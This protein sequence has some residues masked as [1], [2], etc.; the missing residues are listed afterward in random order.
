MNDE[1]LHAFDATIEQG[2]Q[3]GAFVT[4]PFDMQEVFGTRGR[5][6]VVATF[7]GHEY[8]GSI[9]PMGGRHLVI[10]RRAIREAIGKDV[11]DGVAV[12]VQKDTAER[13]VEPPEEL[14][15]ALVGHAAAAK[16]F[17]ALSYT[18]QRE[19]A[20]WVRDAKRQETRDRRAA[21][22]IEML[23]EGKTR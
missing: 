3:G 23:L 8:R 22:A 18:H 7:D 15:G 4:I 9:S 6:P 13:V 11:G 16:K 14:A 17:A 2:D 21:S 5:V 20:E 19:F 1:P 12:T 10:I